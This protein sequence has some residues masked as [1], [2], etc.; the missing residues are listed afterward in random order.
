MERLTE[1][2]IVE[3]QAL[4][5]V[6]VRVRQPFAELDLASLFMRYIP[7]VAARVGELGATPAAPPYGRYHQ[8]GPE[9]V[10]VEIGIGVTEPFAGLPPLAAATEGEIGSSVLPAGPAVVATHVGPYDTLGETYPR[11][12]AWIEE[13]GETAGDAPWESYVD[14][15]ASVDVTELRTEIYW[16]L[17]RA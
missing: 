8:F 3:L 11:V 5:A 13:H 17:T 4:P 1:P 9:L 15:P 2:R 7:A 14:D 6:A 10:D 12:H 16:P